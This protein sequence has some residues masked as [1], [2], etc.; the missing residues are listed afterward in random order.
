M[1]LGAPPQE[2]GLFAGEGLNPVDQSTSNIVLLG[3][4]R[5]ETFPQASRNPNTGDNIQPK[6]T[7]RQDA[8]L[9]QTEQLILSKQ[10]SENMKHMYY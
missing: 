8:P 5:H 7:H 9:L 1:D 10:L 4:K 2:V 6:F 3:D